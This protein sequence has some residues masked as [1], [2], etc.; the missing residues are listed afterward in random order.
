MSTKTPIWD[1]KLGIWKDNN[2]PWSSTSQQ[3]PSPLWLFGYASV[4]WNPSFPFID[5]CHAYVNGF[6][7]RFWQQ[8][9]DH[10][11][12]PSSPG[13]VMTLISNLDINTLENK[14]S[15]KHSKFKTDKNV[16]GRAYRIPDNKIEEVVKDLDFREKGG[17]SRMIT[18][19]HLVKNNKIEI[20]NG[21]VYVAKIDNPH[22]RY[23][24]MDECVPII[25]KSIGPSGKNIDYLYNLNQYFIDNNID[26]KIMLDKGC[27]YFAN[28]LIKY[29]KN[30][31]LKQPILELCKAIINEQNNKEP[32]NNEKKE[33]NKC[34]EDG[35]IENEYIYD[36]GIKWT[37]WDESDSC[38]VPSKYTNL[39]EEITQNK[40]FTEHCEKYALKMF[41]YDR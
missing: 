38:Y 36:F 40:T 13:L 3:I 17:Y 16:Y 37:Y 26:G 2:L 33:E 24:S 5:K 11:G 19:I 18:K 23:L 7:R 28:H 1:K 4:C 27:E 15:I 14:Y 30:S 29:L 22:F 25:A 32:T 8:S 6:I 12:T 21:L 35:Y 41:I 20:V 10:R 9:T 39:K 31:K 34:N